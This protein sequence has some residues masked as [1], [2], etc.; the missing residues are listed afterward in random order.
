MAVSLVAVPLLGFVVHR[1][2]RQPISM[3]L[4]QH[5][6][7]LFVALMGSLALR[8]SSMVVRQTMYSVDAVRT[9]FGWF[10]VSVSLALL[11]SIIASSSFLS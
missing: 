8:R 10:L 2:S 4:V 1:G 6:W 5:S 7:L 11:S 3:K 9:D